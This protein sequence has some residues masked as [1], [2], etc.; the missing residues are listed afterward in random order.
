MYKIY[1]YEEFLNELYLKHQRYV[2]EYNALKL[3]TTDIRL[4]IKSPKNMQDI[5]S[6]GMGLCLFIDLV[7]LEPK[8]NN[9]G[10][11]NKLFA[12]HKEAGEAMVELLNYMKEE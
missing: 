6:K 12:E 1:N 8:Y 11:I 7:T 2:K 5:L 3:S 10:I 4:F 9:S